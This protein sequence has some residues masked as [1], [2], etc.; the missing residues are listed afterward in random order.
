[1]AEMPFSECRRLVELNQ[2]P[3]RPSL[4]RIHDQLSMNC[5]RLWAAC[6]LLPITISCDPGAKEL[7]SK[8]W[9]PMATEAKPAIGLSPASGPTAATSM[10]GEAES[11]KL[12]RQLAEAKRIAIEQIGGLDAN[13]LTQGYIA[14]AYGSRMSLLPIGIAACFTV[15][16]SFRKESLG[17]M[18][19]MV[20][21]VFTDDPT[22]TV[23]NRKARR[24]PVW[25]HQGLIGITR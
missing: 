2:I 7:Q 16:G 8:D 17:E 3:M 6:I 18:A 25:L 9:R 21:V 5:R 13:S 22:D 23:F 20:V 4:K 19:D 11:L 10:P 15:R 12:V 1:M 24:L 14:P